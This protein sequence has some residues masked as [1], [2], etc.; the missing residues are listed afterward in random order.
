[1]LRNDGNLSIGHVAHFLLTVY[2][3]CSKTDDPWVSPDRVR[4]GGSPENARGYALL[5][6]LWINQR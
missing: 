4:R 3:G 5:L 6:R 1:M 2:R